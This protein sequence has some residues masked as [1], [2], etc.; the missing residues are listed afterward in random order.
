M[1]VSVPVRL[2]GG[3]I[4]PEVRRVAR[5]SVDAGADLVVGQGS[6][7]LRAMEWHRGRV[8]AYGLGAFA[9]SSEADDAAA[10]ILRLTL[11]DDGTFETGVLV[12][13]TQGVGGRARLDDGDAALT[14]VERRSQAAFGGRAVEIG[15][16][17]VIAR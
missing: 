2:Q 1:V 16:D 11:R 3:R 15:A 4:P 10:A 14:L 9:G 6:G 7:G 13:T 17:G 5:A 8:V 12:P